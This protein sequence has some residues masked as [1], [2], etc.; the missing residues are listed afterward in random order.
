MKAETQLVL[1]AEA[2]PSK[3]LERLV[4]GSWSGDLA[5]GKILR[6]SP[7]EQEIHVDSH[8]VDLIYDAADSARVFSLKKIEDV[9]IFWAKRSPK[10]WVITGPGPREVRQNVL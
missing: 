7:I 4:R 8:K 2:E 6:V 10:Q 5:I 1:R 9:G 3:E